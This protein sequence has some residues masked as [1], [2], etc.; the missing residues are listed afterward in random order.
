M[1]P[2]EGRNQCGFAVINVAGSPNDVGGFTG[3][4]SP[5]RELRIEWIP[6]ERLEPIEHAGRSH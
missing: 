1:Y 4:S 6:G 5:L 2:G 3:L